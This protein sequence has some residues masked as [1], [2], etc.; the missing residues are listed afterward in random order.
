MSTT[1]QEPLVETEQ[2]EQTEQAE[3]KDKAGTSTRE[4]V[5]FEQ[6]SDKAWLEVKRVVASDVEGA[7]D[8]LGADLKQSSKYVAVAARY[9]RPASPVIETQTTVTLNF[10]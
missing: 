5:V 2:D 10:E 3:P 9:W 6:R 1:Q 7:L 8:S 4:Y